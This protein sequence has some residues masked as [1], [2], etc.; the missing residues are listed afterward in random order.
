[1]RRIAIILLAYVIFLFLNVA[2]VAEE[3]PAA[4]QMKINDVLVTVTWENNE[5]TAALQEL[6]ASG[7]TIQMSM[8]GGFEQVGSI[9]QNLPR[10]DVQTTTEAGDI[11]LYSGNQIVVF[12]GSNSW[13]YTKLGHIMD[14]TPSEMRELLGNGDVMIT[15]NMGSADHWTCNSS[16]SHTIVIDNAVDPTCTETG[17]TEG[18]HCSVCN[19]VLVAQEEIPALGHTEVVDEA[20]E[21]TCTETG[22][23]EGK[24]CSVC[25]EILVAQEI[26][27][28]TGHSLIVHEKAEATTSE[29]GTEAYWECSACGKLFSDEDGS[30]EIEKPVVIPKVEIQSN[31]TEENGA[32]YYILE[33][34][35]KATGWLHDGGSWY[36]FNASGAMV[37][38]WITDG[39]V[40]Y[41]MQPSG[42]MATGWVTDGGAWY[43]MR[44]SGTMATGWVSD[45]GSWY[46]MQPS[47]A[48]ATGWI[49]DGGT[50]Y[51]FNI[52]GD[53]ATGWKYSGG[54]W[55]Y[56]KPSGAMAAGWT[57][58]EGSWYYFRDSGKMVTGWFE[59]KEAEAKLPAGQKRALWYWFD[60]D[61]AMA[62]GWKEIDGQWE[63]FS[64]D[65]EWLYTWDGN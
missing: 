53:M 45:G 36:F 55:Y 50:W 48:M 9:G 12:Y 20:K 19:A 2:A 28:A 46:Y 41:Y 52:G 33:N 29:T 32:W 65:G 57:S 37:T 1:M 35:E 14:K 47:G 64:N 62:K 3:E 16:A 42:E 63:M 7:I 15:I 31:W 56:F 22:L 39:S 40:W 59:D 34:G 58:V 5:S 38:G 4:M 27:P 23:T 61:G 44:P 17:L 25:D 10:N 6:A 8:Y 18:E 43:Y 60:N 49:C 54:I 24:H 21:A 26:V 51:F 30:N 11:V 13:A